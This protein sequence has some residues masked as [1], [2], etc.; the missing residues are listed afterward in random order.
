MVR[1]DG[2]AILLD[3]GVVRSQTE[4]TMTDS[5]GFLGQGQRALMGNLGKM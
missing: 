3:L 4:E 2:R 5:Q 1:L